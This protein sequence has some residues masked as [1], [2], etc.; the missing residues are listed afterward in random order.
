[1]VPLR[2]LACIYLQASFGDPLIGAVPLYVLKQSECIRSMCS[3]MSQLNMHALCARQNF[4]G[5]TESPQ[6]IWSLRLIKATQFP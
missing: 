4:L 5:V 6:E 3:I 2:L 1:M